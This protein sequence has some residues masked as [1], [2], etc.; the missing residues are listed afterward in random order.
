MS[1]VLIRTITGNHT[2]STGSVK[3]S[4]FI[5]DNEDSNRKYI[6]KVGVDNGSTRIPAHRDGFTDFGTWY[7]ST[8]TLAGNTIIA[9]E[10][11]SKAA[12]SFWYSSTLLLLLNENAPYLSV[13]SRILGNSKATY[14]EAIPVFDGNAFLLTVEQAEELGCIFS[15]K[16]KAM[17][18]DPS[19]V[20]ETFIMDESK[21]KYAETE[22]AINADGEKVAIL[23][24]K[25]SRRVSVKRKQLDKES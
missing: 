20:P 23:S 17:Y 15:D 1:G 3:V 22:H 16:Y 11:S 2:F 19:E 7:N 18:L 6:N 10:S 25:R 5:P 14:D 13:Q 8:R 21:I 4:C 9:V 12:G 24:N